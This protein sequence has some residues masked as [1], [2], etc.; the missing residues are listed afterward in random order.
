MRTFRAA[1]ARRLCGRTILM[2]A[3][4]A[5]AV[6]LAGCKNDTAVG[7]CTVTALVFAS[8][9]GNTTGGATLPPVRVEAHDAAGAISSCFHGDITVSLASNPAGVTLSGTTTVAAAAGVA[10]FSDLSIDKASP[11]YALTANAQGVAAATSASFSVTPGAATRLV[12]VGQPSTA[13]MA[14]AITPAVAVAATDPGGNTDPSFTT[15]VTVAVGTDPSSGALSGTTTV[16]AVAGVATFTGLSIDKAGTG[17]TLTANASGVSAATSG[18]F[19]IVATQLKFTVQPGTTV[20]AAGITPA[21]AV[22]ATDPGGNTDAG[23]TGSVTVAIGSNPG[24]GTLSGTKTVSAVAGV[25]TFTGLSIDKAGTGYSFT[26]TAASAGG[27]TSATFNVIAGAAAQLAFTVQPSTTVAG[28][29]ITPAVAVTASDPEGNVATTYTGAVTVT[30]GSN[31]GSGTLSGTATQNA[32]AGVA[33]FTGLSINNSGTGYTL[34][35]AASS[36]TSATSASFDV[37][38]LQPPGPLPLFGHVV[39]VVEENTSFAEVTDTTMPYLHSLMAQ[40]GLATQYYANTHPSIGN[41]F[42]MTAGQI[43]TNDDSYQ[44]TVTADNIVRHLLAAGKTW[45]DYAE[46]LPSVGYTGPSSGN[47]ARKHNPLSFFS[48]VVN[49]SVQVKRLVPFT[50]F[51]LDLAGD[52]L[53]NYSFVVPNLC[54]DAHDCDLLTADNWLK[55][56]IAPLLNN[57]S[58]K[59]DGMLIITFD[60][61]SGDDTNGGGRV[62]W[63][64]ISPKARTGYT[65]TTLYQHQSTLRLMAEG[66]GLTSFPGD[67]ASASNMAEF[68]HP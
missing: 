64:V 14:T 2:G 52:T 8:P 40:Y 37:T 29:G 56:N 31:P 41:Y 12:F 1:A 16:A 26:A 49:D 47:Y 34:V 24:S 10:T 36:L 23:F 55:A 57:A 18:A 51:A 13:V 44:L 5:L 61:A 63:T 21:I 68:F 58:F 27:A 62:V 60:E 33:T 35:A 15:N 50:Q 32:V 7:A 59:Q 22:S 4:T 46:D 42:E 19:S 65:S 67:A 38:A 25:A 9:P 39:I 30:I 43:I 45:K 6:W 3:C 48:D 28:A 66:L 54:N 20:A 11:G 53:P 17:Y